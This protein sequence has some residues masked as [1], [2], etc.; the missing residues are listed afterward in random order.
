MHIASL[1]FN[2]LLILYLD[3]LK[4]EQYPADFL[5]IFCCIP[6]GWQT[7]KQSSRI[8]SS[9]SPPP[10]S[11]IRNHPIQGKHCMNSSRLYTR[12]SFPQ[13]ATPPWHPLSHYIIFNPSIGKYTRT[14]VS[15]HLNPPVQP[16]QALQQDSGAEGG[17]QREGT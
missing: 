2:S 5:C 12:G 10:A 3:L 15:Y 6:A 8:C 17:V 13:L 4:Q 7:W 9:S 11:Q 14:E 1:Y 16:V